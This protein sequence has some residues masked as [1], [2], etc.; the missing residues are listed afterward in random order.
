MERMLL[1]VDCRQMFF[2]VKDAFNGGKLDYGEFKRFIVRESP[3]SRVITRAICFISQDQDVDM[4]TFIDRIRLE[5]YDVRLRTITMRVN[6]KDEVIQFKHSVNVMVAVEALLHADKVDSVGLVSGDQE[7]A[8][9]ATALR[10]RGCRVEVYGIRGRVAKDLAAAAD[11]VVF[12]DDRVILKE[13]GRRE[14]EAESG[15]VMVPCQSFD[16][17][18][19]ASGED[20]EGR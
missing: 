12:I 2:G 7:L 6:D 13:S 1:L 9:L 16:V 3:R 14:H 19:A 4:D 11:R 20:E 17:D 5:G 10:G 18:G 15:L 8:V